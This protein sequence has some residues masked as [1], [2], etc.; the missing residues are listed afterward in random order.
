MPDYSA[1]LTPA[2]RWAVAAYIRALQLSQNAKP[3]DAPAGAK[4]EELH[5][6]AKQQGMDTGFA[7]PW[8]YPATAVYG[9]PNGED[10]GIPGQS[11]TTPPAAAGKPATA[12]Q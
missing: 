11:I 10:N 6:I 1:Q 2:D 9:T 12:K 3:G 5:A 7:D 4:T 8:G